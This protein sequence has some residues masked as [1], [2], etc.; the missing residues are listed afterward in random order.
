MKE[1]VKE[2]EKQL[3]ERDAQLAQQ[4]SQLVERD[5]T[6][7]ILEQK[8]DAL[9]QRIF[10]KSS[11]KLS[12]EEQ[13]L[14]FGEDPPGKP[15]ASSQDDLT[16]E[17]VPEE[18]KSNADK[19]K[20]KQR[21]PRLPENLPTVIDRIIIPEEVL[22]D[23]DS[24][25]E[26]SED[27]QDLLDITPAIY[28]KRRTINKKYRHKTNKSQPPLQALMPPA[29]IPGTMCAPGFA[30]HL[31]VS[32]Y[33]DHLPQYRLQS[34]LKTRH[35]IDIPRQKLNR[36]NT[37]IA[38]RL[39]LISEVIKAEVLSTNYL[40]VD[41]TPI[42]YLCPGNGKTKQGYL[43]IYNSP[44]SNSLDTGS[45][46]YQWSTSRGHQNLVET[47]GSPEQADHFTGHLQCDG[48]KAYE[49]YR[50]LLGDELIL[51]ACLA[52]IR[53]KFY[54]SK[55]LSPQTIG[56]ILCLFS[57]LYRIESNLRDQRAGPRLRE[58]VR[59][60]Q[61]VPLMNRLYKI[62][63]ILQG[64]HSPKSS[65]TVAV[66]YAL[67]QW[68]QQKEYLTNGHLEIDNNLAENAVRPTKLG[69]KNW[70]FFGDAEAGHIS[71]S[72]YTII[73][74]C[75]RQGLNPESYLK[76]VLTHLPQYP[77]AAECADLTPRSIA[78]KMK[79]KIACQ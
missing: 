29:P 64:K 21:A 52:H 66:N 19:K 33:C 26:I 11:E 37:A 51:G 78:K 46:Y 60:A 69:M 57:H 38:Q 31:I 67:H 2:L 20:R 12:P 25:E 9:I 68:E 43:W 28:L 77:S 6:I 36:W 10:G 5:A 54:E 13:L 39:M 14:L 55:S 73:E 63:I 72:L 22:A 48:Y 50:N 44:N 74:N 17:G 61:S 65:V 59:A 70:L 35:G 3:T 53:R 47:L 41:E 30:A 34:I 32:K 15:Q 45:I 56:L 24:W 49:T 79:L 76:E 16:N 58:A 8:I 62:I 4:T 23:P 27:Y 71:A 42:R 7:K 18:V 40:Q 75:K 1:R